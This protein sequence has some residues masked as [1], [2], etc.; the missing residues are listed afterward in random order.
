[1]RAKVV[2]DNRMHA[3]D[4]VKRFSYDERIKWEVRIQTEVRPVGDAT[5]RRIF[6]R[7]ANPNE[8]CRVS[9]Q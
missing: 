9:P 3:M 5:R 2:R 4:G 6:E 7:E 1:M 8:M